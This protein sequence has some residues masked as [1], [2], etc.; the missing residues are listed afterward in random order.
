MK[1][2]K[3]TAEPESEAMTTARQRLHDWGSEAVEIACIVDKGELNEKEGRDL[4]L[5]LYALHAHLIPVL[6]AFATGMGLSEADVMQA[7][8]AGNKS[9]EAIVDASHKMIAKA[10]RA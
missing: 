1:S 6:A 7:V 2:I 4:M 5:R 3:K 9:G 10:G 8:A